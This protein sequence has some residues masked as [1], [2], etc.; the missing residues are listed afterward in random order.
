MSDRR[1]AKTNA[2]IKN[3]FL[4]LLK[5]KSLNKITVAE[6]SREANIGR[7]TFY[8]HYEDVYALY[9]SIEIE[10]INHLS[11]IFNNY[12]PTTNSINSLK[13]IDEITHYIE[14]N[15]E[16]FKILLQNNNTSTIYKIKKRFYSIVYKED[17][18][19]NPN[20]NKEFDL[21]ESIFVVSGIIGVFEKWIRDDFK[22]SPS[23]IS[24]MINMIILKI[25]NNENK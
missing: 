11:D 24:K 22:D 8:L 13:M 18:T 1:N 7:G 23:E 17:I 20:G 10:I 6:I 2:L 4:S 25:N 14:K 12:F 16:L 9:E 5:K 15:K 19:I 3:T 21:I